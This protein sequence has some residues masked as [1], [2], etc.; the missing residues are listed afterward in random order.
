MLEYI[1]NKTFT[2]YARR[3]ERERMRKNG[4]SLTA[5]SIAR[6]AQGF[7]VEVRDDGRNLIVRTGWRDAMRLA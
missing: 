4:E 5:G 6:A 7:I 1:S 3:I 2:S